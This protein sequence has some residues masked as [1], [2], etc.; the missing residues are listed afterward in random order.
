MG[1]RLKGLPM[2]LTAARLG[3]AASSHRVSGAGRNSGGFAQRLVIVPLVQDSWSI[4]V[5]SNTPRGSGNRSEGLGYRFR[6]ASPYARDMQ[7][8]KLGTRGP[9]V[10][11]IGL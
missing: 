10:S 8:R 7:K 5:W 1:A 3:S 11:A 2:I 6:H 4:C 9:E